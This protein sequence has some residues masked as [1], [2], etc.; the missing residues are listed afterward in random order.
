MTT[1]LGLALATCN[2]GTPL[3]PNG[4]R[5]KWGRETSAVRLW[6]S[7]GCSTGRPPSSEGPPSSAGPRYP[8]T[9]RRSRPVCW[10]H[11]TMSDNLTCHHHSRE[12]SVAPRA[13]TRS[14]I[15]SVQ[16]SESTVRLGGWLGDLPSEFLLC[17]DL[18]HTWRPYR[19]WWDQTERAYQR[20][21]RCGRCKS[22]RVQTL[23]AQGHPLQGYYNYS[24]G[25]QAPKGTGRLVG[26]DRDVLRLESVL[27]LVGADDQEQ[28][29]RKGA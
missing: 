25:Y 3:W 13:R 4:S 29:P 24:D 6:N 18:G 22:E 16:A 20:V 1:L 15:R 5:Q 2:G 19:A 10:S 27:R 9:T 12:A 23:S 21:L 17:R 7:G 8:A 26:E 11:G 28:A 14:R